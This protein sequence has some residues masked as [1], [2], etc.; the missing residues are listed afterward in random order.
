[1]TV[2]ER[3]FY[4]CDAEAICHKLGHRDGQRFHDLEHKLIGNKFCDISIGSDPV[5]MGFVRRS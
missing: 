3:N 4:S 2:C 5:R 1:M